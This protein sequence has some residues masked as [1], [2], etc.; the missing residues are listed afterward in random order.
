MPGSVLGQYSL[1]QNIAQAIYVCDKTVATTATV[2]VCNLNRFAITVSIAVS[3]SQTS[4]SNAEWVEWQVEVGPNGTLEKTGLL[5]SPGKYIVVKSNNNNVTASCWGITQGDDFTVTSIATQGLYGSGPTWTTT[6]GTVATVLS[7][8]SVSTQLAASDPEGRTVTYSLASGSLPA[9]VTLS[10]TGLISGTTSATPYTLAGATDTFTVNASDGTNTTARTFNI[11]RQWN[12][13]SSSSKPAPSASILRSYGFAT[14][15]SYWYSLPSGPVQLYTDFTSYSN[16]SFVLVTKMSANDQNQYF[17]TANN[18]TDLAVVTTNTSP[19]R[20][21]KISDTDLNH[22]I[23]PNTVRWA[24]A[25]NYQIFYRMADARPWRSD[26]GQW[27]S[28]G[29]YG[30]ANWHRDFAT[31]SNTPTWLPFGANQAGACGGG[32]DASGNWLILTGIHCNDM[33]NLG[34]YTGS[35]S[36]RN[37]TFSPYLTTS[38]GNGTWTQGGYVLLSW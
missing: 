3:T 38:G 26:F 8:L 21:S 2:N 17:P 10:S 16:Y 12:D 24:M 33:S 29:P 31:P 36:Y 22:I 13:G 6:S 32:Q 14:N 11:V 19:S 20:S 7:G 30:D 35:S 37:S 34:A 9:G 25:G 5:I 28:C 4:P 15:G 27:Q 1:G 18:Q 23:V